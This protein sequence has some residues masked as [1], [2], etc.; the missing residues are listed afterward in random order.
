MKP[1]HRLASVGL[2]LV[3]ASVGAQVDHAS[4]VASMATLDKA[5]IPAL[6]LTGQGNLAQAQAA[7]LRFEAAWTEFRATAGVALAH[8]PGWQDDQ[9]ALDG[10]VAHA[11]DLVVNQK[12]NPGAHEA[13]E[14]VRKILLASRERLGI[15]YFVDSLTRFH[16]AMEEYLSQTDDTASLA[17]L[18]GLARDVRQA[19]SLL[20]A[21]GLSAAATR[22]FT[23]QWTQMEALLATA[24]RPADK[25]KVKPL[26]IK[27]FFLFGDFS[28]KT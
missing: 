12:D 21:Y 20:P 26:F 9:A 15:G 14:N 13:L 16:N 3:A 7:F 4:V 25:A 8:E 10:V 17:T 5:Y 28:T 11:H 6:G 23:E 22:A 27:T 18:R 2:W 19:E 24:P 1:F